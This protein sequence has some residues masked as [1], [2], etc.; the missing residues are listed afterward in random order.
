ML[1]NVRASALPHILPNGEHEVLA[2]HIVAVCLPCRLSTVRNADHIIVMQKGQIEEEG[3]HE[4]LVLGGGIYSQL[5]RR[6]GG[7]GS[8]GKRQ[9]TVRG[10]TNNK[11][12]HRIHTS[13]GIGTTGLAPPLRRSHGSVCP[14]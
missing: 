8:S 1:C 12:T 3:T 14:N 6:Q 2:S 7:D 9:R 13:F 11:V 10:R 4:D 5:V